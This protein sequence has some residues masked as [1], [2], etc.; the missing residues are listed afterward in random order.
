MNR[1]MKIELGNRPAFIEEE[2][3][4]IQAQVLPLLKKNSTFS[5]L[6]F[7]LII[8]SLMNLIYLMF[9]QPAGTTSKVSIGFFALTGA[10]GMALSKESKLLNKEILKNSRVY[11]EKRIQSGIYLSDQRKAA[12]QK[13]IAEQPVLVMKH[14]I[15]FLAEEERTKKRMNS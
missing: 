6:S 12:Y 10:L 2:L 3:K 13:Q 4:K 11:I 14:F 7:M 15:E 9:M 5:T 8:F 1:Q